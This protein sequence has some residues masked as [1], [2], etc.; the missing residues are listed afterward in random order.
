[1]PGDRLPM[2]GLL[3]GTVKRES[4]YFRTTPTRTPRTFT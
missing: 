4:Q 2:I 1:M 3:P